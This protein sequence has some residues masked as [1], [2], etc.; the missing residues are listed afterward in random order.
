VTRIE[1]GRV[2]AAAQDTGKPGRR[3]T[4]PIRGRRPARR[5]E[6]DR[7]DPGGRLA[8]GGKTSFGQARSRINFIEFS[9]GR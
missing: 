2:R 3:I 8:K 5:P 1:K 6:T 9:H 7:R 4:G